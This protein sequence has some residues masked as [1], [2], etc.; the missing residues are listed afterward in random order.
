MNLPTQYRTQ[1][2][3]TQSHEPLPETAGPP[4]RFKPGRHTLFVS[5]ME[6]FF[7]VLRVF[8]G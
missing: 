3:W 8:R 5:L 2:S 4:I 1:T 6:P 7:S